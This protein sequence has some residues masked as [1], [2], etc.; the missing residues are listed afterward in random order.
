[1]LR[2][3]SIS[4]LILLACIGCNVKPFDHANTV[5][6]IRGWTGNL[7]PGLDELVQTLNE[8]GINAGLYEHSQWKRIAATI[9]FADA[10]H[11]GAIVLAGHSYGADNAVRVAREL[12]ESG[13]G[14]ELLI[15]FEANSPPAVPGNVRRCVNIFRSNGALDAV[16]I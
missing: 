14:V 12:D 13:I 6:V 10:D 4:F 1:M 2:P 9:R 3:R 7:S 11:R 5:Y 15:A 8:A 16:P